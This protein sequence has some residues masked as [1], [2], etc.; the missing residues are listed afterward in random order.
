MIERLISSTE[1]KLEVENFKINVPES[2]KQLAFTY[3][4][5]DEY[6]KRY[7]EVNTYD[8]DKGSEEWQ[9]FVV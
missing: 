8:S 4:T 7:V 3:K 2:C 5:Y 9:D 6:L 1:R